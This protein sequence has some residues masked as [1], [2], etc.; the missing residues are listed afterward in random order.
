MMDNPP[1]MTNSTTSIRRAVAPRIKGDARA[2]KGVA[3]YRPREYDAARRT[4]SEPVGG[5]GAP[6]RP[7]EGERML[8][9]LSAEGAGGALEQYPLPD[10]TEDAAYFL[11]VLMSPEQ[12]AAR[13]TSHTHSAHLDRLNYAPVA[14]HLRARSYTRILRQN[15]YIIAALF[16]VCLSQTGCG[17]TAASE[18]RMPPVVKTAEA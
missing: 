16:L 6:H 14:R 15:F 10:Y 7:T 13:I 2:I 3:E 12:L 11:D 5:D 17:G 18:A 1:Q 4:F 9:A 8:R